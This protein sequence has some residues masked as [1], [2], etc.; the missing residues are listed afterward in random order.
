MDKQFSQNESGIR[1]DISTMPLV[2]IVIL[3]WNGKKYLAQFLPSVM[4]STYSNK[5]IIVA[6][7][8][9][10]DDSLLFLR[11]NFPTV[12]I[13][14]NKVNEG[15][16][17]GYNTALRQVEADY[18]VLLN[19]DVEVTTG[20]IEPIITLMEADKKIAGCQ[21]KILNYKKGPHIGALF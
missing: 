17:N 11:E 9:S 19:S 8:A 18:Y 16:A 13:L 14:Q 10:T 5:K 12:E 6:D 20:W 15:F 2:A 7:N 21:P 3:N 1:G 4:K